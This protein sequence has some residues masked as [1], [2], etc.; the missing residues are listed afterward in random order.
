MSHELRTPLNSILGFAELLLAQ[1]AGVFSE[2]QAHYL[3]HIRNAG[4]H[5]LQ[6]GD[7]AV[8][9]TRDVKREGARRG[10]GDTGT[11]A[12][13]GLQICDCRL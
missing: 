9:R 4:K 13:W 1:K 12:G 8:R 2:K 3:T 7:V 10:E 11:G 6:H 5:L